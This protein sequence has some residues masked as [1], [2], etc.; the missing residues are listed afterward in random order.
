MITSA[1]PSKNRQQPVDQR[2]IHNGL[3][4]QQF[5]LIRAGFASSPTV[6]LFYYQNTIEILMPGRDHE[7]FK[8][9]IGMLIELFC[10]ENEVEFEPLGSTPQENNIQEVAAEPDESYCFGDSKPI[11]DLAIEVVFSTGGPDKLQRYQALGI[12]EVWFWQ[13]GVLQIYY[14]ENGRY[15]RSDRSHI[16]SLA[17]LK[18]DVLTRCILVAQTSGA[19]DYRKRRVMLGD[20]I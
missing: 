3:S 7:F 20:F 19:I 4:W 13:D 12:P 14:L 8:S 18:V 6:R 5:K 10:L 2:L 1:K 15:A 16:P 11:P 9:I 17:G